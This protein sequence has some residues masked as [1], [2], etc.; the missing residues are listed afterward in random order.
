VVGVTFGVGVTGGVAVGVTAGVGVVGAAGAQLRSTLLMP[1][2]Q[3][4]VGVQVIPSRA[5]VIVP[6]SK[7]GGAVGRWSGMS[8]A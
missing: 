2:A 5:K 7:H 8:M 1:E 4:A 3:S 6:P